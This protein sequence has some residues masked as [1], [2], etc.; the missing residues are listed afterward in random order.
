MKYFVL[1]GT[2]PEIIKIAPIIRRLQG[3][4]LDYSFI[5]T[6]QHY[7][8]ELSKQM[9]IDL[10][11]N[12]PDVSLNLKS[13]SPA[14]QIAEI[15]SKLEQIMQDDSSRI[16]I[17]QGDTNSVLSSSLTAIKLG[18]PLVHIEAGLR[19]YDW[20]MPEEHNRRMVDHISNLLCAPTETAKR[21]LQEEKVFGSI[22]VTGNT[23]IDAVNEHLPIAERNSKVLESINVSEY[24]LVTVHRSENVDDA[25]RLSVIINSLINS[26]YNIIFPLH[27]RTKK[28]LIE[29]GLFE[30]IRNST[31]IIIIP[32][33]GYLDFL[34]LMKNSK[35]IITDSGGIQEEATAESISKRI[36]V[37]R[38]STERPEA[39]SCGAARLIPIQFDKIIDQINFEIN[40]IETKTYKCPYGDGYASKRIIEIIEEEKV[41]IL[42]N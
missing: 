17:T 38:D 23:V 28:R 25:S 39:I 7:D 27:P 12:L 1:A 8:Y 13:N 33:Q 31:S 15:M 37:L 22:Y 41:N 6:G 29:F 36:L 42:K 34:I 10:D 2:R 30:K 19:S 5:L 40:N 16:V 14:S 3:L 21:N 4:Q 20:R 32:P 18:I 35:F 9:I 11:L 24:I 26:Q